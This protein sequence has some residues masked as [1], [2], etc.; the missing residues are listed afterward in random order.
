M[1]RAF[2]QPSDLAGLLREYRPA[3]R[4]AGLERLAG[5]SKK[6]VYRVSFDDGA[7]AVVYSW[8][9]AENYWPAGPSVDDDPFGDASGPD[10]FTAAEAA[11]A[12]AGVRT[13]R[14]YAWDTSRTAVAADLA[15]VED[16]RGGSLEQL[17]A[18]DPAS[19]TRPLHQ[20]GEALQVMSA[21]H[22]PRYGKVALAGTGAAAQQPPEDVVLGR[23]SFRR[24][25][26]NLGRDVSAER[27]QPGG[28]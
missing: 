12:A 3:A 17:I 1:P 26:H 13:P 9:A 23:T 28:H 4:L 6:G 14:I 25:V 21:R 27:R 24:L 20:L 2:L 22:G 18:A 10:L 15:L 11:L 16:V 7:T 8:S 5:S 19:V